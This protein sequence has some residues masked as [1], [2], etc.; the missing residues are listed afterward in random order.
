MLDHYVCGRAERLSPEAPVPV[1]AVEREYHRLGGAA[2]VASHL[3]RMGACTTLLAMVGGDDAG[4][5]LLRLAEQVGVRLVNALEPSSSRPTTEKVRIISQGRA[6][7]SASGR[8]CLR[9]DIEETTEI[10][11]ATGARVLEET[12]KLLAK[13][14]ALVLSDYRKGMLP[15]WL[16]TAL[17]RR[18]RE[19]GKLVL[20]DFKS[21]DGSAY[22][23]C[24]CICLNEQEAA[25]VLGRTEALPTRAAQKLAAQLRARVV[26]KAA[27]R[28]VYAAA[29]KQGFSFGARARAARSTEGAGDAFLAALTIAL[30]RG[31][32]FRQAVREAN[33][34][35][36]R[37]LARESTAR[38][39][40]R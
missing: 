33:L 38:R 23:G 7:A 18:C 12:E 5:A 22:R 11:E 29:G 20:A 36:G 9:V 35:A 14:H 19:S 6:D 27:E 21:A 26:V 3:A 2:R 31:R 8:Q 17:V 24:D 13:V 16:V 25:A 30:I 1:I 15:A 4:T 32:A 37:G 28:G 40:P 10:D 39:K 34:A